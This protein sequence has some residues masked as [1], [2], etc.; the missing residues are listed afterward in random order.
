MIEELFGSTGD[1][2]ID[3]ELKVIICENA[4]P[5]PI[6]KGKIKSVFEIDEGDIEDIIIAAEE[7][8][9]EFT[10]AFD[11]QVDVPGIEDFLP[12]GYESDVE[13]PAGYDFEDGYGW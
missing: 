2:E 9:A 4:K 5:K 7:I 6:A 8:A 1:L 12:G 10:S 13:Y 3:F 11:F